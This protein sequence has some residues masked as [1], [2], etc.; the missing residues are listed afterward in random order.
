LAPAGNDG[1][2]VP[3]QCQAAGER[4]GALRS[5]SRPWVLGEARPTVTCPR[6]AL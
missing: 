1:M 3:H 4:Q 6:V 2:K 5:S